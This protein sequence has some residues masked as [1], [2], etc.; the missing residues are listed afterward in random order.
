MG[1][2]WMSCSPCFDIHRISSFQ[3]ADAMQ[4]RMPFP[5][6]IV[7]RFEDGQTILPNMHQIRMELPACRVRHVLR[8]KLA[9]TH[10]LYLPCLSDG[11]I[12]MSISFVH[13]VSSNKETSSSGVRRIALY[14]YFVDKRDNNCKRFG[15]VVKYSSSGRDKKECR[16]VPT[17][18]R[19]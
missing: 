3:R 5:D 8:H 19:T 18:T 15:V 9:S 17:A 13:G 14:W 12:N 7:R 11:R 1:F 6:V 2:E 10:Q 16:Y 4:T